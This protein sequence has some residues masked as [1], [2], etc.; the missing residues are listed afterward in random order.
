M[1]DPGGLFRMR[2]GVVTALSVLSVAAC[3]NGGGPTNPE[4]GPTLEAIY[5]SSG[6][7]GDRANTVNVYMT[8]EG[9]EEGNVRIDVSTFDGMAIEVANVSVSSDTYLTADFIIPPGTP[10]GNRSVTVST[11]SGTSGSVTFEIGLDKYGK[12][13]PQLIELHD[14]YPAPTYLTVEMGQPVQFLNV[15]GHDHTV[16]TYGNPG[17]WDAALLNPDQRFT[18]TF[19]ERG[20]YGY[21]CGLHQSIGFITVVGPGD[22]MGSGY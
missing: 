21:M 16:Q 5:P 11:E 7:T 3:E 13:P 1:M 8:G 20:V 17:L 14:D 6:A 12:K 10:T 18:L 4:A 19:Y 15:G 22:T 9:F 2:V